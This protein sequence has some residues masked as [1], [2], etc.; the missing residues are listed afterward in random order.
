M[1]YFLLTL[2]RLG[3]NK[4]LQ[5]FPFSP[6][7]A[8]IAYTAHSWHV[9]AFL[10]CLVL[11]TPHQA[12]PSPRFLTCSAQL[13]SS[14]TELFRKEIGGERKRKRRDLWS[15]CLLTVTPNF[16]FLLFLFLWP[17]SHFQ[18]TLV[19]LSQWIFW[20]PNQR[21]QPWLLCYVLFL[22][23]SHCQMKLDI[24]GV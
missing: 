21:S 18:F 4:T 6:R 10:T 1:D 14:R 15:F 20:L 2:F 16:L 17:R 8:L 23:E 12:L 22:Y 24:L 19:L 7:W 11:S 13:Q 3:L 9:A 5:T